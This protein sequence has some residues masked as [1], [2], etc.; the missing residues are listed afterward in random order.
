MIDCVQN[1]PSGV[2]GQNNQV[3]RHRDLPEEY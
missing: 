3:T 1:R 2:V